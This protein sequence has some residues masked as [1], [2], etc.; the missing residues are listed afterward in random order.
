M[1]ELS[2]YFRPLSIIQF[3]EGANYHQLPSHL[4]ICTDSRIL[5]SGQSFIGISGEKFEADQFLLEAAQK[6]SLLIAQDSKQAR[7]IIETIKEQYPEVSI[8]IVKN[9]VLYLQELA[10]LHSAHWQDTCGG[11]LIGIA[12]SNGKTTTKEML[13]HIMKSLWEDTVVFTKKNNNN[14]LGVPLTLLEID[15]RTTKFAVVEYGSNHPGEM[16]LLCRVAVPDIGLTTNIGHTHMEFFPTLA[17]VCKEEASFYRF[18]SLQKKEKHSMNFFLR[19]DDD[20]ELKKLSKHSWVKTFSRD[21]KNVELVDFYYRIKNNQLFVHT[22]GKEKLFEIE[23]PWILGEHNF[24]NLANA[25]VMAYLCL[26]PAEV[27]VEFISSL[28][29]AASQFRPTNNRSQWL[30]SKFGNK[31]FLDAYNANP[32]SMEAALLAFKTFCLQ[33]GDEELKQSLIIL[34]D[35]RELGPQEDQYHEELGQLVRTMGWINV[36]YV[37][38]MQKKFQKGLDRECLVFDTTLE[39]KIYWPK[40]TKEHSFIFLKGSRAL[41]LESLVDLG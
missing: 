37:G 41:Q 31:I 39:A 29:K 24:I 20:L 16:E 38:S 36:V 14:H 7:S 27:S 30:E 6:S 19:N 23:N 28:E 8:L 34:A 32:S 3:I 18:Q 10:Q 15:T 1:V 40:W 5:K 33:H 13:S 4:E 25:C 11:I 2:F 17:D 26:P 12:G 22:K 35:M 21:A 9:T